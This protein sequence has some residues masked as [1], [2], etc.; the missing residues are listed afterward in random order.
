VATGGG[1]AHGSRSGGAAEAAGDGGAGQGAAAR[2][3]AEGRR[4]SFGGRWRARGGPVGGRAGR[5]GEQGDSG[6]RTWRWGGESGRWGERM[7]RLSVDGADQ[8]TKYSVGLC[9]FV[10]C[11][12]RWMGRCGWSRSGDTRIT[13]GGLYSLLLASSDIDSDRASCCF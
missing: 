3:Y 2:E 7:G 1:E 10:C 4:R 12:G 8:P 5:W 9:F 6:K 11:W 13:V